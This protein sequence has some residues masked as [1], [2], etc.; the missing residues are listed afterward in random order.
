MKKLI[1][2]LMSVCA[3]FLLT[4]GCEN[5][6]LNGYSKLSYNEFN[7]KKDNN[8]T[9][10]LVIG[11]STCSACATYEVVMKQF[12]ESYQVEVFYIDLS[13]LSENEYSK[14]KTEISFT[15]TPTTVFYKDGNLT[16]Y[17]N[18]LDGAEDIEEIKKYLEKNN[19]IG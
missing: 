14:L 5:N 7:I 3:I 2:V 17:Y 12:I 1:I 4:T 8:D 10:P 11:S 18:R 13:E 19:Y 9:F 6:K 15:G 16:S